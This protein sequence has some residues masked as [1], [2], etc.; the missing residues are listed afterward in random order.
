M[1]Q[2]G[3]LYF[4]T[5]TVLLSCKDVVKEYDGFTQKE[6]EFLLASYGGKVWQRIARIED[7]E[8]IMPDDCGLDNF[9]I[10]IAN[11]QQ[12]VIVGSP[13]TLLY[14]YNPVVCDSLEFCATYPEYCLA[15]KSFCEANPADCNNL[16]EGVLYIGTWFAKAPFIQN[17]PTD[18]LI[19]VINQVRESV[20]VSEISSEY[21]TLLY[22]SRK[23]STGGAI[24]EIYKFL[25]E[26][27]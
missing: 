3:L 6:M 2:R 13:K 23:T 22:G 11:A 15:H 7:G 18:S 19:F 24:K 10:F 16:Q 25:S 21:A 27:D 8:E 1:T 9:M 4:L 20:F 12:P 5:F 14:A 17:T 26:N